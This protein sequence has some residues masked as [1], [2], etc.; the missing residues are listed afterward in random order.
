MF[1]VQIYNENIGEYQDHEVNKEDEFHD[2]DRKD[3]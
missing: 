3:I 1:K 2:I